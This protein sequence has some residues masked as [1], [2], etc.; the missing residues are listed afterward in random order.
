MI[1]RDGTTFDI[2]VTD[3]YT[4]WLKSKEN[5]EDASHY[6]VGDLEQLLKSVK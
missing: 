6:R 5:P 4:T 1:L 2:M 3:V